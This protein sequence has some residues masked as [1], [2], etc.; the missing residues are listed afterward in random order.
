MFVAKFG[1]VM[2]ALYAV[3][4]LNQVNDRVIVPFT[5]G[6]TYG[7]AGLLSIFESG[8][9]AAGTLP[10]GLFLT[11]SGLISG[12]PQ[13]PGLFNVT[14]RAT[15]ANGCQ[16]SRV[17]ALAILPPLPPSGGPTLSFTGLMILTVL[18]AAAGL[19][20]MNRLSN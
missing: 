5:E 6:V 4:A 14:I 13:Q 12:A 16:G 18:L 3:I 20:V 17:Y 10:S 8:D 7:A 1:G 15:D 9:G 2:L 11:P 19:F